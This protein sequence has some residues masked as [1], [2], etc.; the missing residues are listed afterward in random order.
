MHT[1]ILPPAPTH[2]TPALCAFHPA[3][4]RCAPGL[5]RF[6]EWQCDT[7]PQEYIK[8]M[9]ELNLYAVD[10]ALAVW[11]GERLLC[12]AR[13]SLHMQHIQL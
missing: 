4:V 3:L 5:S 13:V 11:N 1:P 9:N 6:T 10:A 12:V 2:K 7:L 8:I